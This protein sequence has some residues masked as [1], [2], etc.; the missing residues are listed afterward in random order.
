MPFEDPNPT[1]S[2]AEEPR[3]LTRRT[4]DEEDEAD[5]PRLRGWSP[6]Q[7]GPAADIEPEATPP[8]PSNPARRE[9]L[10][11][12]ADVPRPSRS[13]ALPRIAL[14]ILLIVLAGYFYA[15]YT[16]RSATV[17]SL[18]QLDGSR[19]LPGLSANVEV[20]RDAQGVPHIHAATLDD[21]VLAQGFVTAQDRLFQ[22]DILRRH[23]A[24]TLAELFGSALVPHDR[25]Q[26]VLMIRRSAEAT[27]AQLPPDQQHLLDVYAR[28]VNAAITSAEAGGTLPVEFHILHY[29]PA[30]WTPRDSVLV[31][32][33]MFQNLT[34][35]FSEKLAREELT[36]RLDSPN[37]QDLL[38]DLYPVGSWRDHPPA[39]PVPDLTTQTTPFIQIPLDPSQSL[40]VRPARPGLPST[41]TP[42]SILA[43]IQPLLSQTC[44]GCTPG[45]NNWVVSGAHTA[46]GKPLLSNDMHLGLSVPDTWYAAD[47]KS[48]ASAPGAA[49][50]LHVAGVSLPGVPLI[51]VGHNRHIAWG[52]TNLGADVQDLYVEHLRGKG[53]GEQFQTADNS[54]Q[55]VL[56]F[57][58]TIIVRGSG[59]VA[60]DVTATRHGTATTPVLDP[61][62]TPQDLDR[63]GQHRSLSLRWTLNDP[64]VVRLPMQAIASA[65]DWPSFAAAFSTFGG[66]AQNVVYADDQGH[67]GYHAVGRIPMRGPAQNVANAAADSLPPNIA[68][69]VLSESATTSQPI[70]ANPDPLAQTAVA[71]PPAPQ[72]AQRS[73]PISPVPSAA[74]PSNAWSGY[75]PY[76]QLPQAFDPPGG[77]IA[78]AN[79]RVTPDD[80]PYPITLNWAA[81]YRNERIWRL[82][83]H[84]NNLAPADMLTIQTDVTSDFD[85]VLAQRLAYAIDHAPGASTAHLL[86]AQAATLHQA[87][88][89]L[90]N[91]DGTMSTASTAAAI[92]ASTHAVLWP[93]LLAPKLTGVEDRKD[94]QALYLWD[95]KDFAL[96]QLL[97]HT[98]SRWLSPPF[99]SWDD[100]LAAAVL[101]GLN[102]AHAPADL[103]RFTYGSIQKVDIEHPLFGKYAILRNLL[104]RPTG[105]GV[106]AQSGDAT[107]I[108]QVGLS[109]GPSERFTA[110]L[111]DLD[112]ST[113][114]LVLGE[115]GNPDSPYFLDQFPAWLHGTSYPFPFTNPAISQSTTHTLTLTP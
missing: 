62:L 47:L 98:P 12:D 31:A 96:E 113:L 71:S 26:R 43:S 80:Y 33:S 77:V 93:M 68:T 10:D 90:R 17:E 94:L 1:E 8:Y 28:G 102:A 76:N 18:P 13:R 83:A 78:T 7:P 36:N 35:T 92:V 112:Q 42:G 108:K 44:D 56:H 103:T 41:A 20:R 29:T 63:N 85:R 51:V 30:P 27:L 45:S 110:S 109:F 15:R 6:R 24:G 34:D 97:E 69:P 22:M 84:R 65:T 107:T 114:N 32:M 59:N 52:F 55:S 89:L 60:L 86:A 91:F 95:E 64:T 70:Q 4:R 37:K 100:L 105:T 9:L 40:V 23:A 50:G 3:L 74:T 39:E 61:A 57:P 49:E 106:Q 58:E 73:G 54:W 87:A 66:P 79:A 75:I 72:T 115:S 104:G 81:P 38:N 53:A 21:L 16:I 67:I 14:L 101:R 25:M 5:R 46:S 111:A 82:L 88:D 19:S 11:S 2:P 48:D 99:T